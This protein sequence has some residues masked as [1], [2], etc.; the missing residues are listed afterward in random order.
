MNNILKLKFLAFIYQREKSDMYCKCIDF[1]SISWYKIY[2]NMSSKVFAYQSMNGCCF[3]NFVRFKFLLLCY[4]SPW[5]FSVK[6]KIYCSNMSKS[7]NQ[8]WISARSSNSLKQ[9]ITRI[10]YHNQNT[11]S[12]FI[13]YPT[14]LTSWRRTS[15][16]SFMTKLL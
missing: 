15:T 3:I 13:L 8:T 1:L 12:I 7:L 14:S 16:R 11:H 6:L 2:L 4:R 10:S 9:F 5:R